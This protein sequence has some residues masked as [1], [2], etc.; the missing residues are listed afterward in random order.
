[1]ASRAQVAGYIAEHLRTDRRSAVRAAAAWLVEKG[2]TRQVDYLA[3]D[4]ALALADSGYVLVRVTSARHLSHA[5][6]DS[7]KTFVK[8]E[9][10]ARTVEIDSVI[11]PDLLGGLR[12]ETPGA[13]MDA[14]V[15]TKLAK[16]VAGTS[17]KEEK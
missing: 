4:V 16:L 6:L 14:S 7:V 15:R 13:T 17:G 1:M 5:A 3:R 12:I 8:H 11:D 10:G 9:T 2:R